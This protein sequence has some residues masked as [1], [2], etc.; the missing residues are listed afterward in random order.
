MNTLVSESS[1][2]AHGSKDPF[3]ESG[4]AREAAIESLSADV[5]RYED[6]RRFL[7]DRFFAMQ[8]LEPGFS[9]R[10]LARKAGIA[11]PGFFNEVIKGRRRLSPAAAAKMA[12]GLDLSGEESEYFQALV[13]YAETREPRA[14][15]A[16]GDRLAALRNRKPME[17]P[18]K[19]GEPGQAAR[20]VPP[21]NPSSFTD[22]F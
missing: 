11:N 5:F 15:L 19:S 7:R 13:E 22:H 14:K 16:A 20:Q 12:M 17:A 2:N 10:G 4:A 21:G 18:D 1:P 9:Q 6:Y 3:E 8:S